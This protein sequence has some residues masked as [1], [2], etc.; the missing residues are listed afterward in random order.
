MIYGCREG[1]AL[2]LV[3]RL[4]HL[5][6][7]NLWL[8][9]TASYAIARLPQFHFFALLSLH[10]A[11]MALYYV[12][13]RLWLHVGVS[14]WLIRRPSVLFGVG[15][16]ALLY[17]LTAEMFGRRAAILASLLLALNAFHVA[18]SQEARSHSMAIFLCIL[19]TWLWIR[20]LR[21]PSGA[22]RRLWP[23]VHVSRADAVSRKRYLPCTPRRVMLRCSC[24]PPEKSQLRSTP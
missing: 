8:D 14:T 15:G 2:A 9:E 13:M 3:V 24:S 1:I 16:I 5:G 12:L 6:H 23:A 18:Y 10:E 22:C 11:N 17:L 20:A 19:S 21:Q 4:F 7:N